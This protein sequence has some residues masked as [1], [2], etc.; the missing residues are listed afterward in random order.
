M[1]LTDVLSG[2]QVNNTDA[3]KVQNSP[4]NSTQNASIGRQIQALTPGQTLQGEV[5]SR[6][7]SQ[8]QI[9]L[10]DD[11]ILDAKVDRNMNLEVG[12]TMTFEVRNN[13]RNLT[14]SPLFANTAS[15]ENALK[16]LEMASLPVNRDTVYMAGLMMES[17]LSID[18]N[19]LQLMFREINTFPESNIADVV[20][21]HKLGIE[22]NEENLT[23]ISSY[24][25]MTHQLV[26]GMHEIMG[27][28]PESIEAMI[29]E[30]NVEGAARMFQEL[31]DLVKQLPGT[32]EDKAETLE[33]GILQA[34]GENISETIDEGQ[35]LTVPPES[36][37][38]DNVVLQEAVINETVVNE[39]QSAAEQLKNL[40]TDVIRQMNADTAENIQE[41]SGNTVV[42]QGEIIPKEGVDPQFYQ[43]LL[44]LV[45]SE[46]GNNPVYGDLLQSL[47]QA[48]QSGSPAEQAEALQKIIEQGIKDKDEPFV[49]SLLLNKGTQNILSEG[50]SKLWTITPKE[51]A[52]KGRVEELYSRL[53][54]QLRDLSQ[55]LE[56]NGQTHS[57][58]FKSVNNMAQNL[59]FM[60]QINHAYTY[61]QLPLKLQNG[62]A[63][64]DLYV[65]TN[66]RSLASKDGQISALLHLDMEHLGPVDVYVAMQGDNVNTRFYVMDEML[67]F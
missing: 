27:A 51:V 24:K 60:Q 4:Q 11:F 59:D 49:E 30:G 54:K 31:L 35:T 8:V 20:D 50:I 53:G 22:V 1:K 42:A 10:A 65:Y 52:E 19:S 17:G 48:V 39:G 46:E 41:M 34:P 16:A 33:Q 37:S 6:N 15:Q 3:N 28:I 29:Q 40:L 13:G 5:I 63:H 36:Q 62:D 2:G 43:E 45:H 56:N 26:N 67:D 9:K 23:Q 66:K 25:N 58:A 12:K 18:K 14:L 47:S 7:G 61:V 21:L 64:G 38:E 55:T 44:D 57:T 32:E